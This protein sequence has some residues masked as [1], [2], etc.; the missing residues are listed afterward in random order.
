MPSTLTPD[1]VIQ[2]S[3]RE[4]LCGILVFH[5]QRNAWPTAKDVGQARWYS[6]TPNKREVFAWLIDQHYVLR[7][8]TEGLGRAMRVHYEATETGR[9]AMRVPD[10]KPARNSLRPFPEDDLE[11]AIMRYHHRWYNK[12][13]R[14]PSGA[15]RALL[16]SG[17]PKWA[18]ASS[19]R[20]AAYDSLVANGWL[21][22]VKIR[23]PRG[24]KEFYI[25]P[26][27]SP[28]YADKNGYL[29][30]NPEAA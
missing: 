9:L 6:K 25:D 27:I 20:Q 21:V 14:W 5:D 4:I 12:H 2:K 16:F 28:E 17:V 11:D 18:K 15:E 19:R 30:Y 23:G 7:V 22:F 26:D 29:F 8:E 10:P 3:G 13:G 1:P 24:H